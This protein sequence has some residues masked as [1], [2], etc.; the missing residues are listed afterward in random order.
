MIEHLVCTYNIRGLA[1]KQAEVELFLQ[2]HRPSVMALTDTLMPPSSRLY[3]HG[4]TVYREVCS[5]GSTE[6]VA[7]LVRRDVPSKIITNPVEPT[8]GT[9][10]VT[11]D[12]RF[13]HRYRFTCVYRRPRAV[14]TSVKLLLQHAQARSRYIVLGDLNA[15][16][17]SWLCG[18]NNPLGTYITKTR[19]AVFHPGVHTFRHAARPEWTS[20]LD[21]L[22]T[23]DLHTI[24][25]CH[26]LPYGPSDHRPVLYT[27]EGT[28]ATPP[29]SKYLL[30]KADWKR[31]RSCVEETLPAVTPC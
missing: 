8:E 20:T 25:D 5:R 17:T 29:A 26:A 1:Q 13:K 22:L 28:P 15:R 18:S 12:V 21:L 4:Y 27:F 9:H 24:T 23:R 6:G 2:Q 10:I 19:L 14:L 7:I 31:Y 11:V 30:H 16:H 3:F